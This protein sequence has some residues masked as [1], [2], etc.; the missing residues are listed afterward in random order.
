MRAPECRECGG[1]KATCRDVSLDTSGAVVVRRMRCDDC[2]QMR[3]DVTTSIEG[4]IPFDE[5]AGDRLLMKREHAYR[6]RGKGFYRRAD[7]KQ[8]A[9]IT[10]TVDVVRGKRLAP[11]GAR[12]AAYKK[13]KY[14]T[15]PDFRAATLAYQKRYRAQ[16]RVA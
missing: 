12:T 15:D 14:Q 9:T 5:L 8:P 16:R 6:K 4:H 10:V 11:T 2:G 1:T 3:T 7:V 13:W